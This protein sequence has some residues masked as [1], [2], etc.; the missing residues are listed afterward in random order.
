MYT[1]SLVGRYLH[2]FDITLEILESNF[3]RL[4]PAAAKI[5]ALYGPSVASSLLNL[6]F[7]F[8]LIS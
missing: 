4:I 1:S 7:K 5:M 2:E 6:V 8:P 3:S